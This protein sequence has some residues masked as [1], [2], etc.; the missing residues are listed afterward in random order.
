MLLLGSLEGVWLV[1]HGAHTVGAADGG[2]GLPF[3]NWSRGH[4]DLRVAHFFALHALQLLWGT[5]WLL[6]RSRLPTRA[7][8]V[9]MM[10]GAL[11]YA[12]GVCLLFAQA[13]AGHAV[14]ALR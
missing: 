1:F 7:A 2:A 12:G 11:V 8:T 13:M 10:A 9:A 6:G 3:L 14:I 4:G 5:G